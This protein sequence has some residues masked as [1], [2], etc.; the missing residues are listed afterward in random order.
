MTGG[1]RIRDRLSGGAVISGSSSGRSGRRRVTL[2]FP[3]FL[4]AAVALF[5]LLVV[6]GF[7]L[8]V[9]VTG[10]SRGTALPDQ[11]RAWAWWLLVTALL[12]FG[13]AN[14]GLAVRAFRLH[15][16]FRAYGWLA[17]LVCAGLAATGVQAL[18][19]A[20]ALG[21]GPVVLDYSHLARARRGAVSPAGTAVA[22]AGDAAAGQ[23]L[24][25]ITCVTCHGPT[26]EGLNSLA[27]S[28]RASEFLKSADTAG[29]TQ[30]V[31]RG[32]PVTDPA[33]KSGKMMPAKGGNPFLT[34]QQVADLVAFVKS[35]S[36]GAAAPV[37]GSV[38]SADPAAPAVQM[39][40]LARWVVPAAGAPFA[41]L[42]LPDAARERLGP[43][44]RRRARE[45]WRDRL[46]RSLALLAMAVHGF[47]L[48]G[49]VVA[50][51]H[52]LFGWL[53]DLRDAGRRNWFR[54]LVWGWLIAG[55]VWLL[56]GL[57]PGML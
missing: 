20:R 26:G 32:R 24:F 34:D 9:R 50:S 49:V 10:G 30:V 25:S 6:L 42:L 13:L 7:G 45:R 12:G 16:S 14:L 2:P 53:L 5:L 37:A 22:L 51:S 57:L 23:K 35:I 4:F 17:F 48:L 3:A 47:F 29:V 33:N 41:G 31:R 11:D 40:Q 56:L 15:L 55:G 8:V 28:L 39:P 38:T 43:D 21:S 1:D 18:I 54:L 52:V 46:F 19:V 44:A 27:P 36:G